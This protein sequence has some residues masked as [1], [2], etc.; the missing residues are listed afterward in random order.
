MD[1]ISFCAIIPHKQIRKSEKDKFN[2]SAIQE[3]V[4]PAKGNHKDSGLVDV[5]EFTQE[6]L[7]DWTKRSKNLLGHQK[8]DLAMRLYKAFKG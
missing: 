7:V 1:K 8:S 6:H 4:L 3:V 5:L 2:A